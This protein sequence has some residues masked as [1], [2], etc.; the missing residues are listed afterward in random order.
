MSDL[1][2]RLRPS[3]KESVQFSTVQSDCGRFRPISGIFAR[4]NTPPSASRWI[5]SVVDGFVQIFGGSVRFCKG[6]SDLVCSQRPVS[7]GT[8]NK[9][10][11]TDSFPNLDSR[12]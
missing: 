7:D 3:V 2:C 11:I 10:G 5:R 8:F 1:S 12:Q 6:S 9:R 4:L